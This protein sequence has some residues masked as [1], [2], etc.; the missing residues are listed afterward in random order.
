VAF[1]VPAEVAGRFEQLELSLRRA[2]RF[3]PAGVRLRLRR[4]TLRASP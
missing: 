2:R 3:P 1:E 4:L